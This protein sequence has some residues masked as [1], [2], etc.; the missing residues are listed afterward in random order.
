SKRSPP[1]GLGRRRA[2]RGT[3][4]SRPRGG[5]HRPPDRTPR[6]ARAEPTT[7]TAKSA[8]RSLARVPYPD[9]GFGTHVPPPRPFHEEPSA[10]RLDSSPRSSNPMP[11]GSP[12]QPEGTRPPHNPRRSARARFREPL[13]QRRIPSALAVVE[14][15]SRRP[16]PHQVHV[17]F[18][19]VA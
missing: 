5:R 3:R 16:D 6:S 9:A 10:S 14:V 13:E 17:D 12:A 7:R 1:G 2:R 15:R 4:P 11:T 8:R 18:Q 19:P